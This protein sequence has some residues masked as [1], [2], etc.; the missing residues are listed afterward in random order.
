MQWKLMFDFLPTMQRIL[1]PYRHQSI[2]QLDLHVFDGLYAHYVMC[3]VDQKRD[4]R[5]GNRYDVLLSWAEFEKD[6]TEHHIETSNL[7]C[8]ND[9]GAVMHSFYYCSNF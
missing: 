1:K 5:D 3:V 7:K 4:P 2:G 6:F 9:A 8:K